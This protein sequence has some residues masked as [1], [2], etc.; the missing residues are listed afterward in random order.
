LLPKLYPSSNQ[1]IHNIYHSGGK[2]IPN[3]FHQHKIEIGVLSAGFKTTVFPAAIA[4][5]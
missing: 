4:E 2:N 1:T 3:Q 5:T